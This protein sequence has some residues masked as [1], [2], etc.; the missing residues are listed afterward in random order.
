MDITYSGVKERIENILKLDIVDR[1]ELKNLHRQIE[2]YNAHKIIANQDDKQMKD[3]EFFIQ[4]ALF[5]M[6]LGNQNDWKLQLEA[7][8]GILENCPQN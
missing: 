5:L 4:S 2:V 3:L 7:A 6:N 8:L 1:D